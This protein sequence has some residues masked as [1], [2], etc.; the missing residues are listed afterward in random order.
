MYQ[1]RYWKELYQLKVH[2]NYL[3]LYMEDS[4]FKDKVVSV[5]LAL[6]SSTSI[7]G[8]VIWQEAAIVWAVIIASSQ[9]VSAIRGFLPY[10]SRLKALGGL[11]HEIED[12]VLFAERKWFDVSE[13][14]LTEEEI[15]ELQYELRA[16]KTK[17]L[18][19]NLGNN[20]LPEKPKLISKA[21]NSA[22]IY[23][24][25]FYPVEA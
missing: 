2:L 8:W 7:A 9:V 11:V 23:F 17:A 3:E 19:K 1:Q 22:N 18:K 25:N 15:H 6:T 10:K 16:K 24:D 5:F 14:R 13:G 12:L 20:I 21:Q 4:E